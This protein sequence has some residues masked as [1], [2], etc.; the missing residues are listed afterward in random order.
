MLGPR[1]DRK[2]VERSLTRF[3]AVFSHLRRIFLEKL[4]GFKREIKDLQ[5]GEE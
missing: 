2:R 3:R 1:F 4:E 5:E